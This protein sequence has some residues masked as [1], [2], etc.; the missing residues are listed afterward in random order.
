M[1]KVLGRRPSPAMV[2]ALVA[3][4]LALGGSSYAALSIGTG[5][6]RNGAVTSAKIKNGAVKSAKINTGAVKTTKLNAQSVTNAKVKNNTLT[7]AKINESTLGQVPSANNA[8]QLGGQP[9]T[10]YQKTDRW[11][12]VQ[13]T[14]AGATIL[15]QSGGFAGVTR[16]SLGTYNVDTGASV[17]RKP[18]SATVN[19]AVLDGYATA[20]P[21]GG[22][23]NNPG[24]ANCAGV[25]DSTNVRVRTRGTAT[26]GANNPLADRTFYL[27]IGG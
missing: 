3:L 6:I 15:A 7:G 2:V 27:V 17:V 20:A 4:F 5:N 18:L 10:A 22:N 8:N 24:G 9:A 16:T 26:S 23:A 12:L 11:V 13:G 1:R 25:N 19:A 14:A 21:C